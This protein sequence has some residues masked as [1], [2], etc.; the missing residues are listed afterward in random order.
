MSLGESAFT[1]TV[2]GNGH[3]VGMSQT[4]A[5]GMAKESF[6]YKEILSHYYTD[7]KIEKID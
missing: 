6:D 4:G 2:S 1:F 5:N 3:G 7:C